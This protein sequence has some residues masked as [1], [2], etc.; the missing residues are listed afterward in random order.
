MKVKFVIYFLQLIL[1]IKNNYIYILGGVLNPNSF[2]GF[3]TIFSLF[4]NNCNKQLFD[5]S[6]IYYHSKKILMF[7]LPRKFTSK[8]IVVFNLNFQC[9]GVLIP[10]HF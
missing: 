3:L 5:R 2:G 7:L 9:L 1:C 10:E 8:S 4:V 6:L